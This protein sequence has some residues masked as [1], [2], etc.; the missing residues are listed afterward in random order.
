MTTTHTNTVEQN[1]EM[2]APTSYTISS[3]E[4]FNRAWWP[5]A[6]IIVPLI[7]AITSNSFWFRSESVAKLQG[8][9]KNYVD[10][11]SLNL[12]AFSTI[13]VLLC[14]AYRLFTTAIQTRDVNLSVTICPLGV[15]RTKTTITSYGY[16]MNRGKTH[17]HHYP[18]LPIGIVKDCI[19][20]EHVGGLSVT[21]HVMIR[22]KFGIDSTSDENDA[23]ESHAK[24]SGVSGMVAAFPDAKLTFRQCHG[25]VDQIGR[26]L[27]TV[28]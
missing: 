18:L 19:L 13:I 10:E 22:L 4:S 2:A 8:Y 6:T 14:I 17:V 27:Q 15:Q 21:T 25:L 11:R 26:A 7:A 5:M 1:L 3:R 16:D 12:L 9:W 28:Q 24:E 23:V 20:L